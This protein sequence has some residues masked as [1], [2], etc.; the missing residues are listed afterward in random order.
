MVTGALWSDCDGDGWSDL[1]VTVEWGPVRYFRNEGGRMR[2][3]TNEASL[4]GRLGWWN[5][6]AGGDLDGDGDQD[7]LVT[8][9]GL[10]SKYKASVEMPELLYY[11]DFDDTADVL[12]LADLLVNQPTD[13]TLDPML[14]LRP[15]AAALAQNVAFFQSIKDYATLLVP[16]LL[17]MATKPTQQI[18]APTQRLLQRAALEF[19][20]FFTRIEGLVVPEVAMRPVRALALARTAIGTRK[21]ADENVWALQRAAVVLGAVD[22]LLVV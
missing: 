20:I 18:K 15:V 16:L 13:D 12:K 22:A 8:N 4:S 6:I 2:E 14:R 10:N 3:Q 11:G 5:G 21:D 19:E 9:N 1:L 17:V 7:F